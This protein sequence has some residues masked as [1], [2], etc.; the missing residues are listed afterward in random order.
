[1]IPKAQR[2]SL[3]SSARVLFN[4]SPTMAMTKLFAWQVVTTGTSCVVSTIYMRLCGSPFPKCQLLPFMWQT[5]ISTAVTFII[6]PIGRVSHTMSLDN[7]NNALLNSITQQ[8]ISK[9]CRKKWKTQAYMWYINCSLITK[10]LCQRRF[11]SI[12]AFLR[13]SQLSQAI[14]FLR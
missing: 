4:T 8:W 2:T 10:P 5:K 7:L 1:M 13:H 6:S 11:L 3:S 12:T 9:C 14:P